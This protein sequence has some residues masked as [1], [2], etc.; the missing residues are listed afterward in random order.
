M[1]IFRQRNDTPK[2]L[3]SRKALVLAR[4]SWLASMLSHC[5][6]PRIPVWIGLVALGVAGATSALI[7]VQPHYV[8]AEEVV[9][10]YTVNL[11]APTVTMPEEQQV[12]T[13]VPE[14]PQH[15][16]ELVKT[17]PEPEA[18]PPPVL[19]LADP[20]VIVPVAASTA[21][22]VAAVTSMPECPPVTNDVT[23]VETAE[24]APSVEQ[25][26][27]VAGIPPSDVSADSFSISES[28]ERPNPQRGDSGETLPRYWV[29]VRDAVARK[30][31]YPY[32]ARSRGIEGHVVITLTLDRNG[33]VVKAESLP[34]DVDEE[35]TKAAVRGIM[36]ASPFEAPQLALGE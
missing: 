35:L 7:L 5:M 22:E 33:K 13:P 36:R 2:L 17:D 31:V 18:T 19:A 20:E 9:V 30:L 10:S 29:S 21:P 3:V 26:P 15:E 1:T 12:E 8:E 23:T 32:R 28:G 24:S 16:P 14:Q 11:R 6:L 34:T 27:V 25:T 4:L